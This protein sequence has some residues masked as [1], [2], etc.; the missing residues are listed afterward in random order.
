MASQLRQQ[1]AQAVILDYK[2]YK[3]VRGQTGPGVVPFVSRRLSGVGRVV[4][5]RDRV[6]F[7]AEKTQGTGWDDEAVGVRGPPDQWTALLASGRLAAPEQ[8]KEAVGRQSAQ[9]P[10]GGIA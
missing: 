10:H 9:R 4:R 6:A 3:L 7:D 1:A 2:S 5:Q 8:V